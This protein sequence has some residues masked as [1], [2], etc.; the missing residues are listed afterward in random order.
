LARTAAGAALATG[1]LAAAT[2]PAK[3]AFTFSFNILPGAV[4]IQ[5]QGTLDLTGLTAGP[6]GVGAVAL[7]SGGGAELYRADTHYDTYTGISGPTDF[8]ST[9]APSVVAN[10]GSGGAVGIQGY[11][12]TLI[13]PQGY[14]SGS[15]LAGSLVFAGETIASL[16]LVPGTYTYTWAGDS[17]SVVI[18]NQPGS[19][20]VPEPASALLLG[21]GLLGLVAARRRTA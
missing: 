3:A 14:V 13:V 17:L 6:P 9:S 8:G 20:L 18:P 21:M 12:S 7:I 4:Q 16:G 19:F 10:S 5:G 11:F 15:Y 2:A 1:L